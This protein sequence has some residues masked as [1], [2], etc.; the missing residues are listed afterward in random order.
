MEE[1]QKIADIVVTRQRISCR[2]VLLMWL[3]N[4][5][6]RWNLG[7]EAPVFL[8]SFRIQGIAW[9]RLGGGADEIRRVDILDGYKARVQ[10]AVCHLVI[11]L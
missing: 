5:E 11:L 9:V 8:Y 1:Q 2:G 10:L 6:R 7:G 3:M 4:S